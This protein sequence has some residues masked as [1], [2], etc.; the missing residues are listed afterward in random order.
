MKVLSADHGVRA[1]TGDMR[2]WQIDNA[3]VSVLVIIVVT[4]A[5]LWSPVYVDFV[6]A[7]G[8]ALCWCFWLER[9]A[10][11]DGLSGSDEVRSA[12]ILGEDVT[13]TVERLLSTVVH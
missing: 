6:S 1:E 5:L 4:T 2:T 3:L 13:P 11:R 9:R 8:G 7:V 12:V 10:P